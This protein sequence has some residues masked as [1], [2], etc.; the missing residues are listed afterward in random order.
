LDDRQLF[1][2]SG[3]KAAKR[4]RDQWPNAVLLQTPV[5]ASWLNQ[6]EIF[7]SIAQRRVLTPNDFSSLADLKQR[8][9]AA[10][11]HTGLS[12][13]TPAPG[14]GCTAAGTCHIKMR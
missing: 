13:T 12:R 1:R 5:H 11:S 9:L 6:V 10:N 3:Q 2:S 8:L 7:F 4:L 14:Y